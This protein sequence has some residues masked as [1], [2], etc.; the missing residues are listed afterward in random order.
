MYRS[1]RY[2]L[3]RPLGS[4]FNDVYTVSTIGNDLL[5]NKYTV[6]TEWNEKNTWIHTESNI[7]N[8][9]FIA[10]FVSLLFQFTR[11]EWLYQ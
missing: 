2:N 5:T 11:F 3:Q 8:K 10:S 4:N 7:P 9:E 1:I 6:Q